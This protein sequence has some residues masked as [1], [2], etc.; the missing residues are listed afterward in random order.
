MYLLA[1][2]GNPGTKYEHT[3]HN[4]GFMFVDFI[5]KTFSYPPYKKIFTSYITQLQLK[6]RHPDGPMD[7]KDLSSMRVSTTSSQ[8]PRLI[9]RDDNETKVFLIKPQTFMNTSGPEIRKIA[10]FYKIPPTNMLI[11]H[12]DLDIPLGKFKI[13]HSVGPDLHNGISSIELTFGTKDFYRIRIGV[14][15]RNRETPIPGETYV[16]ERFSK[17]EESML[18]ATFPLIV[19]LVKLEYRSVFPFFN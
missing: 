2:L 18:L 9:A 14:D 7:Q 19:S 17:D 11:A 1:G 12:D 5:Q 15:N 16:L 4:A 10:D 6:Y 13:D 3:R 8:I